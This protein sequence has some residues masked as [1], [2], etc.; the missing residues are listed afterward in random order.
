MERQQTTSTGAPAASHDMCA[1]WSV[2]CTHRHNETWIALHVH[3][4]K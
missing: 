4:A 1:V 3:M 2:L